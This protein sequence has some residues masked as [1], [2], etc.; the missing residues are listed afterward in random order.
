MPTECPRAWERLTVRQLITRYFSGPSPTCE[1]RNVQRPEEWGLLKTTAITWAGWDDAAHKVPPS[2]YWGNPS[3]EVHDGDVLVTKAGP[4][5][6]VG[7]VAYVP[8]TRPHL[9]V[10]GK[11]VA[12]RPAPSRAEGRVLAG[13]LATAGAQAFLDQRTTGMAES[14]VNFANETLLQL[15]LCVP[16][17]AEQRQIARVLERCDDAI[18]RTDEIVSKLKQL[19]RGLVVGLLS[20]GI[21]E[22]RGLGHSEAGIW[23]TQTVADLAEIL[24][25]LRVPVN[26]YQRGRRP[27]TVPYY[28]ANGRQGWIDRPLFDEPLILIAEDGGNFDEYAERPI[29]YRVDGPSWVD[30]HAHVLRAKPGVDQTFLLYAVEH[31]DI[32]RYISGGTR[33]KLTQAELRSVEVAI[34]GLSQQQTIARVIEAVELRRL[35]EESALSKLRLLL[36]GLHEEVL[37]GRVRVTSLLDDVA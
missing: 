19:K 8:S 37:S 14:Q 30:N 31:R 21:D 6:R 22:Q 15:T 34:P 1:E 36:R 5:H 17:R 13:L 16:P 29:A 35:A 12:L 4:R 7:V 2:I 26:S 32:R 11:M 18:G 9:M 28:G 20:E 27:G 33:S 23:E 10:S 24:D 3:L 25:H